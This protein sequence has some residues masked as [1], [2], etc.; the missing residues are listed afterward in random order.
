MLLVG[1][2]CLLLAVARKRV[3]AA[4]GK[5]AFQTGYT[6]LMYTPLGLMLHRRSLAKKKPYTPH[7]TTELSQFDG[8]SVSPVAIM[9]A[10]EGGSDGCLR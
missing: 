5:T 7:S 10:W 4:L 2:A 3:G 1:T 8:F 9:D 6:L